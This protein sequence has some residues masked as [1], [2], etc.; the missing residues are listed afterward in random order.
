MH[1]VTVWTCGCGVRYKAIC[2]VDPKC[3]K[4]TTIVCPNC[5]ASM[6]IDGVPFT[7]QEEIAQGQWR[8]VER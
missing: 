6:R 2:E 4:E 3:H 7:C 1:S 8:S 5:E